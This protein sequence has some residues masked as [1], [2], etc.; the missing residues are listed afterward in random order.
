MHGLHHYGVVVHRR[1]GTLLGGTKPVLLHAS[2]NHERLARAMLGE[3]YASHL[4]P[5]S[6]GGGGGGGGSA[7]KARAAALS[8]MWTERFAGVD[9][10]AGG[11]A[12]GVFK[13]HPVLLVDAAVAAA[14]ARDAESSVCAVTTVGAL[15]EGSTE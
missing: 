3:G 14:G 9:A 7:G 11:D 5:L 15:M 12:D 4:P 1:N 2:G 10:W 13:A 8:R 6:S